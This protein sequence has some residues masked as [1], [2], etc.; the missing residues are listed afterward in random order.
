MA[1]K[2]V[3]SLGG[4]VFYKSHF[5]EEYLKEFGCLLKKYA[6]NFQFYIVVGGGKLAREKIANIDGGEEEKDLAGIEATR[7]N[8][9]NVLQILSKYLNFSE[10]ISFT[11]YIDKAISDSIIMGGWKPGFS[12][13]AVAVELAN[14]VGAKIVINASNIDYAYTKDPKLDGAEI[15]ESIS[16]EDFAKVV[17]T[18]RVPGGNY[19]FDPVATKLAADYG[20]TVV[21]LNGNKLDVIEKSLNGEYI[22]TVIE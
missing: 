16:W 1:E 15:I 17:G 9:H 18:D 12:T 6:Y 3:I 2:I 10:A 19:P 4:S 13:D 14:H 7:E 21:I 22:G 20:L 8:A 11:P 5:D